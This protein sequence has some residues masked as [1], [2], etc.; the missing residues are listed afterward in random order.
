M[1]KKVALVTG[2]SRGIGFAI[3][4][5]FAENQGST[6]LVLEISMMLSERHKG[7]KEILMLFS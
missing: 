5:E 2:S 1:V 6:V 4:K 3:S 7:L